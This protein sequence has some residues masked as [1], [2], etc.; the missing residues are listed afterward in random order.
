MRRPC[1]SL[2]RLHDDR[3][4]SIVIALVFF[5]ICAIVGSV[6]LTAASVNM[7]AVQT[8]KELQQAEFTMSSAAQTI[9]TDMELCQLRVDTGGDDGPK[10]EPTD[11]FSQFGRDFW[12]KFGHD[13]LLARDSQSKEPYVVDELNIEVSSSVDVD[14]VYGSIVVDADLN[15]VIDLSL[16]KDPAA[17]SPYDMR[18]TLQCIPTYDGSGKLISFQYEPAVIEKAGVL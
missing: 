14:P 18:V 17:V 11:G 16:E 7:K 2:R 6:I 3:G 9:A 1:R 4:A 13:I 8:H 15:I 10:A 12:R 5:L